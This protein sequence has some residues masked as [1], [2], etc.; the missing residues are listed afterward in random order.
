M[1]IARVAQDNSPEFRSFVDIPDSELGIGSRLRWTWS[2]R[3]H[4][5]TGDPRVRFW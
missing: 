5:A 4:L 1:D 2:R 3:E